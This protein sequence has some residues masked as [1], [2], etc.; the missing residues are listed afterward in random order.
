MKR[1]AFI[2][3]SSV[4]VVGLAT[5][6]RGQI[7]YGFD[8]TKAGSAGFQSLKIGVGAREVALGEA[9]G[10]ITNDANALFW[11]VGALP[12]A[13]G[14]QVAFT[15]NQWLAN[16]SLDAVAALSHLGSYT[17]GLSLLHFGIQSFEETTVTEPDGTGRMVDA[18]DFVVGLAAAK[19]FTD[20]LTIGFQAKYLYE[21]LDQ[22]H[23][24]N[25]LF[26]VGTLYYTGF[27]N[28]RLAFTLQH[29]GPNVQ[30]LR[31]DFRMPLLFRISAA[32]ELVQSRSLTV[33]SA[34][35]L[36]HP[37]D[38][39]EWVNFGLEAVLVDILA[40]R[41]GYRANVDEGEFSIGAGI[42][43]ALAGFRLAADYAYADFG[44]VFGG[45]HRFTVGLAR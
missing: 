25:V 28:L 34:V 40:V 16:S 32:D 36:V 18:G 1:L 11:N 6:A 10:A 41:G 45:M 43:P 9:A 17:F 42:H 39:N 15:H 2:A 33:T 19:R 29:F 31:D 8:F 5:P 44:N 21:D 24:G 14:P 4:I 23:Y 22:D 38:N 13:E 20:K 27:R 30:G 35:E 7:D 26:D 37:T 12:I 3:L